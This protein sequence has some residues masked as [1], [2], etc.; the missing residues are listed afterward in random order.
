M[1]TNVT[2]LLFFSYVG[3][4]FV[5]LPHFNSRERRDDRVAFSLIGSTLY[6]MLVYAAKQTNSKSVT[7]LACT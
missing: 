4:I 6:S 5:M 1:Q 7:N 3:F 2:W